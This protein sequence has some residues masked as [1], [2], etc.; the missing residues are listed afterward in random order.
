MDKAGFHG[1]YTLAVA[2]ERYNHLF[3]PV[4]P[5]NSNLQALVTDG[6]FKAPALE[7]GGILMAS[8]RQYASIV[9]GQDMNLDYNGPVGENLEF[10]VSESLALL[11]RDPRAICV[12]G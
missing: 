9:L 12:L 4:R 6:I 11:I 5:M 7:S 3:R 1:P 10:S 8:G 2:P